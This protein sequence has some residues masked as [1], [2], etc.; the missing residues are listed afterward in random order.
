MLMVCTAWGAE[1]SCDMFSV[2]AI[3]P[4]AGAIF[5]RVRSFRPPGSALLVPAGGELVV[6]VVAAGIEEVGVVVVEMESWS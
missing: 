2:A 6:V 1:E 3:I 5:A 4:P